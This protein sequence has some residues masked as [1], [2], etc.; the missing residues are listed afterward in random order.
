MGQPEKAK[1]ELEKF[2]KEVA[3]DF[4]KTEVG[5]GLYKEF[6]DAEDL[7]NRQKARAD[8]AGKDIDPEVKKQILEK[9]RD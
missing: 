2:E 3:K 7:A 6:A 8:E 4:Q 5:K 9:E 1:E